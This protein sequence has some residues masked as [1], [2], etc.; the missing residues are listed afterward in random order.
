[1]K[2]SLTPNS[3]P[4]VHPRK[5]TQLHNADMTHLVLGMTHEFIRSDRKSPP[6]LSYS[7]N[8]SKLPGDDFVL[9]ICT[10]LRN[11]DYAFNRA[12][13]DNP[14]MT[15][16]DIEWHLCNDQVFAKRYGILS[17]LFL[18]GDTGRS[19]DEPEPNLG[20]DVDSITMYETEVMSNPRC[21]AE[22]DYCALRKW[23]R[24][25]AGGRDYLRPPVKIQQPTWPSDGDARWVQKWYPAT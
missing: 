22:E 14:L 6:P 8:T 2:Y 3:L 10:N 18:K 19:V 1:M 13:A 5:L 11:Y 21:Q 25:P 4:T 9:Y 24:T 15:D 23:Q 20:F 17:P 12:R 16:N 7:L